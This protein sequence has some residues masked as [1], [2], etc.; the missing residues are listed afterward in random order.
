MD[1]SVGP[2][3]RQLFDFS[4]EAPNKSASGDA[5][6]A[7]SGLLTAAARE[8]ARE[9]EAAR[10]LAETKSLEGAD[11]DP[12]WT[13]VVDRRWYER[14]KHIY[15]ASTWQDFDPEKNYTTEVRKDTGGNTFF[16]SG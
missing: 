15:P 5:P 9:A 16:F 2:G 3:G 7:A 6:P 12:T 13:K 8:A 14:N 4:A 10:L 1:K 11:E